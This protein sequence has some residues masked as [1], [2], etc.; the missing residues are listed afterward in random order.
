VQAPRGLGAKARRLWADV[1]T[2]YTLRPDELRLLE[3][4][5][6]EVDLIERLEEALVDEALVSP[7]S[8]GQERVSPLFAEVRQHRLVLARL[9][10]QLDLPDVDAGRAR[11]RETVRS[12]RARR[13]ARERWE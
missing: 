4:A 13:A 2:T 12:S 11:E 3:D 5:A 8:K 10:R 9:L 7:G 6:R 1:T